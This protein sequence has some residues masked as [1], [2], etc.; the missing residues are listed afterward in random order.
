MAR[1]YSCSDK[2]KWTA[3]T[4]SPPPPSRC[5]PVRILASDPT[6]L[7]AENK[8]TIIGRIKN[9]KF[10]RPRVVIDF[11]PQVWNLEGRV[12]GRE[13]GLEKFQFRFET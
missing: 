9:P 7:I 6:G 11:L 10:Q 5:A 13:L 8:L 1:R 4:S 2:K 3:D 12:V